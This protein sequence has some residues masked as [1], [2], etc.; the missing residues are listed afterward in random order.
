MGNMSSCPRSGI[1]GSSGAYPRHSNIGSLG[2]SLS[3][4][5]T[6]RPILMKFGGKSLGFSVGGEPRV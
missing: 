1:L 4:G 2:S 5:M 6:G 3:P